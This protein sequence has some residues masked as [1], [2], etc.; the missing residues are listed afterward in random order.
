MNKLSGEKHTYYSLDAAHDQNSTNLDE[1]F[2]D[3]FINFSTP[4]GLPQHE[5]TLKIGAIVYLL[6]N[7]N[8]NA[9]YKDYTRRLYKD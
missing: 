9:G 8:I 1:V 3:E 6:R 7:L 2:P 4:N 5:L